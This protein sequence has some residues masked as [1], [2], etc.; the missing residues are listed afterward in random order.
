MT[1]PQRPQ[2]FD[3]EAEVYE[4]STCRVAGVRLWRGYQLTV[5]AVTL[6]CCACAEESQGRKLDPDS[7]TIGWLVPAVPSGDGSF[8]GYTSVPD[9]GVDWWNALPLRALSPEERR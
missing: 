9:D 2:R 1:S 8:W 4:C 6:L 5:Q 3:P 7:D